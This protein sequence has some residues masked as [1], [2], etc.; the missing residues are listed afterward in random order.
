MKKIFAALVMSLV[1]FS[2][3]ADVYVP[4]NQ[5]TY[6]PHC[7]GSTRLDC[8]SERNAKQNDRCEI[9]F[10]NSFRCDRIKLYVGSDYYPTSY[11]SDLRMKGSF[12]VDYSKINIWGRDS[13]KVY[14]YSTDENKYE[15]I[16]YQFNY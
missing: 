7:G 14:M 4:Y 11:T 10:S 8:P 1:G 3:M 9:Q 5:W 13:F 2:A 15:R 16:H 6:L 12:Y